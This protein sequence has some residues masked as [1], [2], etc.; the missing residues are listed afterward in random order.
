MRLLGILVGAFIG[1]FVVAFGAAL[2]VALRQ[3][4]QLASRG[5]PADNEVELVAIF[6][7]ADFTSTAGSLRRVDLTAMY[8]GGTLDLRL[9]TLDPAGATVIART[10]T[11][12]YPGAISTP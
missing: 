4:G 6:D 12:F 1:L 9:A 3:K 2:A 7:Q 10:S 5:R 11:S 8:G